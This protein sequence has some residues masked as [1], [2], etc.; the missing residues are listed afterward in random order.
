M[1]IP[2][3]TGRRVLYGHPFE[4][5]NAEAE[6]AAVNQFFQNAASQP[7]AA[8]DFLQHRSVEYIFYGPKERQLGVLPELPGVEARFSQGDV[9]IYQLVS[10]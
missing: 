6:E 5:V 1:F 7:E 9:T 4:T 2:A 10:R 3:H 8:L